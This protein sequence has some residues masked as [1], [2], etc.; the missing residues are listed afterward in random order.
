M[1]IGEAR[2]VLDHGQSKGDGLSR[3]RARLSDDVAPGEDV[4]V[5]DGLWEGTKEGENERSIN[6][7]LRRLFVLSRRVLLIV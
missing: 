2:K 6:R 7:G 5:S 1:V 3:S 4:V